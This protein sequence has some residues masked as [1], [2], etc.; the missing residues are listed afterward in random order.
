MAAEV[1]DLLD[2]VVPLELSDDV[3]AIVDVSEVVLLDVVVI[4]DV[5][6]VSSFKALSAPTDALPDV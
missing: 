2:A 6:D 4:A 3:V 5:V 1:V